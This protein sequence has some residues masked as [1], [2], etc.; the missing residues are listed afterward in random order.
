MV[1][2]RAAGQTGGFSWRVWS[3]GLEFRVCEKQ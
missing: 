3:S 1:G 2:V